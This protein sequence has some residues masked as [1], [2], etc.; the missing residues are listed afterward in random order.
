MQAEL[1]QRQSPCRTQN[2]SKK[3]HNS[4]GLLYSKLTLELGLSTFARVLVGCQGLIKGLFD[5]PFLVYVFAGDS[6]SGI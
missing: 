5:I 2:A 6:P 1:L 3:A 4:R